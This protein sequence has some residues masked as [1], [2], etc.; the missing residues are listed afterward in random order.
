[1]SVGA[2]AVLRAAPKAVHWDDLT[3]G[4]LVEKW[5]QQLVEHLVDALVEQKVV[6]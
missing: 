1:M 2:T 6:E 4:K 3:A 5:G